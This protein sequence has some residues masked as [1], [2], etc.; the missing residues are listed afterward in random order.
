MRNAVVSLS[1]RF[2]IETISSKT[3]GQYAMRIFSGTRVEELVIHDL[4]T[5]LNVIGLALKMLERQPA[6]QEPELA[7]DLSYIRAGTVDLERMIVCLIESSRM[8]ESSNQLDIT[9]FDPR[10]VLEEALQLP[11][12]D[13]VRAIIQVED[14]PD[15]PSLVRL[16][17]GKAKVAIQ[18]ALGNAIQASNRKPVTVKLGGG[19]DRCL[20]RFESNVPPREGVKPGKIEADRFERVLGTVGERRGLDLAIVAMVAELFGGQASLETFPGQG[21]AIV[22]D[23]PADFVA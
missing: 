16:D 19:P 11:L 14:S 3:E 7:E 1:I 5:P 17:R 2:E 13:S 9:R 6:A 10:D 21:S 23:W 12:K 15:A 4:R 20:W 18:Q 8:P 22:M